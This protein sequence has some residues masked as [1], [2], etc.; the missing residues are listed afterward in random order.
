MN[1]ATI[2]KRGMATVV[3][4][5]TLLLAGAAFAQT[6]IETLAP[7]AILIEHATGQV[8]F[9]KDADEAAPPASMSK[10]MLLYLLFE[11]LAQGKISLDDTFRVSER[12]WRMEGS[13]MFVKVGDRDRKSTSLNSSHSQQSRMPSSA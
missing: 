5:A 6:T 8:L 7:R 10:M 4:V 3:G 2:T 13:K 9:A 1:A 12:A 11:Q